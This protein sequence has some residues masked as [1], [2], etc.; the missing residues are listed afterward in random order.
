MRKITSP[1]EKKDI[2]RLKAG[3]E[4][5]LSGL[6]YT[7][8]DQAHKRL[9]ELIKRNKELPLRLN[10]QIIYY[11]G[12]TAA[13]LGKI[14][15]SCGPTSSLRMDEF[16]EPLLRKGLKGMIGKGRRSKEIRKLIRKYQAVYLVAPSGCG[17][18]LAGKV[19]SKKILA[20][21]DLGPE[22]V[23]QLIVEDFP[24]IVG[25]DCRGKG[26]YGDVQV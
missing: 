15:G 22:A 24:L 14:I 16:T 26:L 20:F 10:D 1:L 7:A 18:Y 12:P 5:L 17:A 9:A 19:K 2:K 21:G 25:I 8:R 23:L 4:V 6:I 13:P 11:C 3:D